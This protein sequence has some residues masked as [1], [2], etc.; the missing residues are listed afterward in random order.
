MRHAAMLFVVSL[1]LAAPAWADGGPRAGAVREAGGVVSALSDSA[2]SVRHGKRTATC[3]LGERAP[4]LRGIAVGDRVHMLCGRR[5]DGWKLL[6]IKELKPEPVKAAGAVSALTDSSITVEK[7]TCAIPDRLAE[8]AGGLRVGDQVLIACVRGVLVGVERRQDESAKPEPVTLA[9]AVTALSPR[10]ISVHGDRDLTCSVPEGLA[11]KLGT[12]KVGDRVKIACARGVLVGLGRTGEPSPKPDAVVTLTGAISAHSAGSI[13]VHGERDLTCAI[14]ALYA[15]RLGTSFKVG[16]KVKLA[17][18]GG[19]LTGLGR[20]EE[21]KP[22]APAPSTQPTAAF[23]VLTSIRGDGVTVHADAGD[24]S[25][26]TTDRSPSLAEYHLG[27]SV[28]VACEGG[29]LT[30]IHRP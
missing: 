1:C 18:S 27:D 3:A 7:L 26:R 6:R 9:G 16:D 14:P 5:A 11:E 24:L 15:D 8:K 10:S 23:G 17:C 29:V 19:V 20:L 4:S 21:S 28:K 2:I 25:C 13:T 12:V 30:A 22:P